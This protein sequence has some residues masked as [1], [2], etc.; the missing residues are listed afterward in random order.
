M[1]PQ[2]IIHP[3]LPESVTL[4]D[5]KWIYKEGLYCMAPSDARTLIENKVKIGKWMSGMDN[6][7]AYYRNS[8]PNPMSGDNK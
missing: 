8:A 7:V 5:E 3:P 1:Q 4:V 6:I 2:A